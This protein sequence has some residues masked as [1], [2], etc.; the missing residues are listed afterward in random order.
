MSKIPYCCPVCNGNGLVR[1]GFYNTV[2]G[3]GST[4]STI[5]ETCRTC[6]RNGI[7]WES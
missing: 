2:T 6:Q 5:P 1:N 4:I 7:V 3:I